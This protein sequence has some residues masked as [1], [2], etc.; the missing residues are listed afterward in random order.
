MKDRLTK[1][2]RKISNDIATGKYRSF[3]ESEVTKYK[4][5]AVNDLDRRKEIRKEERINVRLTEKTLVSLKDR[6][7]EEGLPYQTLVTSILHKY[8]S[9]K[10]VDIENVSAIKRALK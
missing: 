3:T 2:E 8:L 6:A 5:M 4:Q 9:G 1:A 7:Q 10:L